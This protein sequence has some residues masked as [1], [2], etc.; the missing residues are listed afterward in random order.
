LAGCPAMQTHQPTGPTKKACKYGAFRKRLKG[1]EPSTFCWQAERVFP[2]R[3]GYP[4]QMRGFSCEVAS[5]D[6]TVFNE[7]PRGLGT[8]WAPEV[9][10]AARPLRVDATFWMEHADAK[11]TQIYARYAPDATNGGARVERVF[12]IG[13]GTRA[14]NRR[15]LIG[16]ERHPA[17]PQPWRRRPVNAYAGEEL[18]DCE[19]TDDQRRVRGS[20]ARPGRRAGPAPGASAA[21]TAAR[22]PSI[23]GRS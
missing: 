22:W 16:H 6:S 4:L 5:C 9:S 17:S 1:F 19:A 12:W 3:R 21:P 23:T 14:G 15:D 18:S 2:A 13:T 10:R 7:K 8:Q 20:Q 11:T